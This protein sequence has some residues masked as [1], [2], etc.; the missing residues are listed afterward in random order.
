MPS[1]E[2]LVEPFL[3]PPG[4]GIPTFSAGKGAGAA[5]LEAY[6]EAL[7]EDAPRKAAKIEKLWRETLTDEALSGASVVLL[8]IPLD[9]GAGIRRGAAYGPRG[10]REALLGLEEYCGWLRSGALIDLGDLFVNPHLLSDEMLSAAQIEAAQIEM[11]R[12]TDA[13]LRQR[14]PVAAL[15]QASLL[16][17]A[18]LT[19]H[20]HL[21]VFVIGGDHSVAWPLTEALAD[22][23]GTKTLG[24][25][26]PDAHTDL[27]ASR[28]GVRI[29]FGTWSFHA[30]ELL[31]RGGKLVQLGIRQ[32][33]K[34]QAHWEGTLGVKQY[35][36]S[37]ILDRIHHGQTE[38]LIDEI[39]AGL[40]RA[41]VEKLYFS[42]DIDGTDERWASATGTPAPDGLP[43]EFLLRV[44]ERL[45][46]EFEWVGADLVEVA[47][48]LGTVEQ[49]EETC[50][51]A[52]DYA[53][54]QIRALL[55]SGSE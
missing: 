34:D 9:T 50:R 52:A 3:R 30:N 23:H 42:N 54:A 29:C 55:E 41:G 51:V 48:V 40:K 47:P 38:A 43:P 18:L 21:R 53:R 46:A 44:I 16:L 45:A 7:V 8:G 27:L 32:S 6:A 49:E 11:Y 1:W 24:I 22:R 2:S 14:L 10:V 31:G 35:W 15:S 19:A 4:Q 33:G 39:I 28:L 17:K 12:E 36:A 5:L 13:E 37:E 25:V 26:Q 20:P